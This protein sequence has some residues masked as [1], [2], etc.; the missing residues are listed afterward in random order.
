MIVDYV[1]GITVATLHG[2]YTMMLKVVVLNC[3]SG[4]SPFIVTVY[5]PA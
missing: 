4:S 1:V 3:S 2:S 5:V